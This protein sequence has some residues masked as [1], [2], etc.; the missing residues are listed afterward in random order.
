MGFEYKR[1]NVNWVLELRDFFF[2]HSE[3]KLNG[4]VIETEF[5]GIASV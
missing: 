3:V 2:V 4:Q 5:S 1:K